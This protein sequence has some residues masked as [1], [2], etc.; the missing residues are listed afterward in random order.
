MQGQRVEEV[1]TLL[2]AILVLILYSC[3]IKVHVKVPK[4]K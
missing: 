2:S 3:V 4:A 1:C